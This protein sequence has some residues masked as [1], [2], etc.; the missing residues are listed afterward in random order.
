MN[1]TVRNSLRNSLNS[2]LVTMTTNTEQPT[3]DTRDRICCDAQKHSIFLCA[4]C[5]VCVILVVS[6]FVIIDFGFQRAYNHL[7]SA[8]E[9]E[10]HLRPFKHSN[11]NRSTLYLKYKHQYKSHRRARWRSSNPF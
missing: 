6:Y 9:M 8:S 3:I 1:A 5:T 11:F 7:Y 4:V 2:L 10:A